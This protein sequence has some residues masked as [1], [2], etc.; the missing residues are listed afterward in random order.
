[1]NK[2]KIIKRISKWK[3]WFDRARAYIGYVQFMLLAYIAIKSLNNSPL[4][5]WVFDNWYFSFPLIFVVFFGGCMVLG[6]LESLVK[7]REHEQE[8]YLV[9]NPE[10]QKMMKKLDNLEK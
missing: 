5:T 3:I 10:W 7:I 1:M 9:T 6:F 2:L 4:R 8:N